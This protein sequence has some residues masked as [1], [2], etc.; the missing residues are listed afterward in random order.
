MSNQDPF[1]YTNEYAFNPM[2][3]E[4]AYSHHPI[5]SYF[6]IW[7]GPFEEGVLVDWLGVRTKVRPACLKSLDQ[8]TVPRD[9]AYYNFLLE[10]SIHT[11]VAQPMEDIS[12][13]YHRGEFHATCTRLCCRRLLPENR[14]AVIP[15]RYFDE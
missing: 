2:T 14:F 3:P 8:E 15:S 7:K 13:T 4:T 1:F 12:S 6:P 9:P 5:F 11:I 10:S